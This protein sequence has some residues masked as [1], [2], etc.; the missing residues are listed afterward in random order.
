M[1][2]ASGPFP[3]KDYCCIDYCGVRGTGLEGTLFVSCPCYIFDC[4]ATLSHAPMG[5]SNKLTDSLS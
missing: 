5:D 3:P 1:K 4:V 2:S